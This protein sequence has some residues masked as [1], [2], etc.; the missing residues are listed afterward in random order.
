MALICDINKRPKPKKKPHPVMTG[1]GPNLSV[2]LPTTM[3]RG[4]ITKKASEKA[5]EV[6]ALVQPNSVNTG[7]KKTPKL[8]NMPQATSMMKKTTITIT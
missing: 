5:P 6:A 1:L 2:S 4:P 8:R 3:P 7:S